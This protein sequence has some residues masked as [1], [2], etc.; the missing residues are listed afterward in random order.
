MAKVKADS[1]FGLR[2]GLRK[3]GR[4]ANRSMTHERMTEYSGVLVRIH[5]A[6]VS[7]PSNRHIQSTRS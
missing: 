4:N 1:S 7:M 6:I 5:K 3:L 2:K